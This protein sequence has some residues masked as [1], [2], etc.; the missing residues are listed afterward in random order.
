[1]GTPAGAVDG[2][3]EFL[4]IE[5]LFEEINGAILKK[6][7]GRTGVLSPSKADD[8]ESERKIGNCPQQVPVGLTVFGTAV[9]VQQND[10]GFGVSFNMAD[11]VERGLRSKDLADTVTFVRQNFFQDVAEGLVRIYQQ[12]ALRSL[13]RY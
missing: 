6:F 8:R 10:I 13:Q 12:N 7:K 2:E 1:L 4:N 11:F 3:A 5:W 9:E